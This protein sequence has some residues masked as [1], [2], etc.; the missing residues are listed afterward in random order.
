MGVIIGEVVIGLK[1]AALPRA[2]NPGAGFAAL[3]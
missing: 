1:D 2:P 3:H